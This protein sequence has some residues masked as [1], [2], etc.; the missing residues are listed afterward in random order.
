[1]FVDVG[2]EIARRWVAVAGSEVLSDV[3]GE[4]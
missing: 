4:V 1:M 3:G 2:I